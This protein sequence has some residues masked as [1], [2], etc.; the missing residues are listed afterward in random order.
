MQ[1]YIQELEKRLKLKGYSLKTIKVYKYN[2]IKFLKFIKKDPKNVLKQD[3]EGYFIHLINKNFKSASIRLNYA[4]LKFFFIY[5]IPLKIN[6]KIIDMPRKEKKLP[7]V[8]T[9]SEIKKM[10][11]VT[12]NLKHKLLIELLYSSGLRIGEAIK[13]KIQDINIENNLIRVNEGKGKKD[14]ISILSENFKK[15]LLVYLCKKRDNNVFLFCKG[16]GHIV[17]KTGQRIVEIAAKKAGI[18]KKVTPHMLRHS[19]AT[20]LLDNGVDIRYIQRLLGHSN[21]ETTQIYTHVSNNDVKNI[22]SPLD[23]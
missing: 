22:V 10:I 20:H 23:L 9:R 7:K 1:E 2:T 21:L 6:F 3:I 11:E 13:L 15:D 5:V 16:N 17:I 19:F 18:I 4:C 14:R 8:L 12:T